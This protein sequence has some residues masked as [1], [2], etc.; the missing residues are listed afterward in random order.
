MMADVDIEVVDDTERHRFEARVDGRFA[1]V[2]SYRP[3]PD[4]LVLVHTEIE[5]EFEGK[6]V[7][8]A[9]V[10]GALDVLRTRGTRIVPRCPFVA[11]Y[12]RRHPEYQDLVASAG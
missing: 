8:T 12:V 10:R 2:I 3:G 1:G 5:P 4:A 6:G 11:A 7:G 9:L